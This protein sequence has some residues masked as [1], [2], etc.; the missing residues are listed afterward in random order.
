MSDGKE[1]KRTIKG[2]L[3]EMKISPT[4]EERFLAEENILQMFEDRDR[5]VA[6]L[7]ESL[8]FVMKQDTEKLQTIAELRAEVERTK[9]FETALEDAVIKYREIIAKQAK[10]IEVLKA[11]IQKEDHRCGIWHEGRK[12]IEQAES[13]ERG[14]A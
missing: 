7:S 3:L 6:E 11:C 12:A 2:L 14:E 5:I 4:S 10:V 1:V 8:S 9:G 13:I